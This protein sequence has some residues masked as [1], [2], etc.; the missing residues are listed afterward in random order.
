MEGCAGRAKGCDYSS[1]GWVGSLPGI[2]DY[3]HDKMLII[4]IYLHNP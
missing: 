4:K 1:I 3:N 2:P